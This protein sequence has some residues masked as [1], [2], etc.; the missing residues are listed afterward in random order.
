M[1]TKKE[2]IVSIKYA[3]R[4][5]SVI[6]LFLILY[7]LFVLILP[8][9]F[10]MYMEYD[11]SPIL[12]DRWMYFG[13]YFII[14][15][16]GTLIPFFLMRLYFRLPFKKISRKITTSFVDLF[17]QTIVF[18]IICIALTYVSNRI[19]VYFS[20][21]GKLI[22]SIG[23]SYDEAYLDNYLYV[24]MLVIVTPIMEE[25][26][27]RGVLLNVLGK[28]GKLFGLY[29]SAILFALAH[30]N[31][32]EYIPAFAMG[33]V[34]GKTSLR[35]KSIRP[36]IIIHILF[37]AL[38]YALCVMPS[39][40]TQ[41]MAYGLAAIFA[42]SV[43]FIYTGRYERVQIQKLRSNKTTNIVFYTCPTVIISMVL[44]ICGTL[45]FVFFK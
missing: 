38:I 31:F 2:R 19:F 3:R 36:T 8:F 13:I 17:V 1:S 39:P 12:Q 32:S 7:T 26:A 25:Y 41:Y 11:N 24:F 15:F 34:L 20:Q 23:F 21:E 9:F 44:M 10:H 30:T 5:F 4:N 40:I 29:A 45:L 14:I 22:S 28:Y 37:N 35:Y 16:F 43:Y 27:F 33:Y 42:L 18:F 6:G